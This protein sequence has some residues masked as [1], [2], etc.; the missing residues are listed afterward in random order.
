[1]V[2][3]YNGYQITYEEILGKIYVSR[4]FYKG[5]QCSY[6]AV[7]DSMQ[8]LKDFID[9]GGWSVGSGTT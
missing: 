1:M 8:D 3:I 9:N 6:N 5:I 2:A 4:A 7:F